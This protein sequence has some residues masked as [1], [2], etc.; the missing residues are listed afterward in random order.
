M[1]RYF[2]RGLWLKALVTGVILFWVVS[3]VDFDAAM[4]RFANVSLPLL[5]A[6]LLLLLPMGSTAAQRWRALAAVC[7]RQLPFGR[8]LL[9]CW[10]GQFFNLGLPILGFDGTRAWKLHQ[11]GMPLGTATYIVVFDRLFALASL[12][13]VIAFGMPHLLTMPDDG[14]FKGAAISALVV[15]IAALIFLVH[16]SRIRLFIPGIPLVNPLLDLSK[17]LNVLIAKREAA[18][19]LGW[20]VCNHLIRVVLVILLAWSIGIDLHALDAFALAPVALLIAM[21]P[22]SIGGWGVR[23]A[24]CIAAFAPMGLSA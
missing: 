23:E 16:L 19:A 21:V 14:W 4:A 24:V 15:S 17:E 18:Y 10:I 20:G 8:A 7:G 5:A 3:H 9:D 13:V 1:S 11:R 12:V 2:A 6:A 22:V